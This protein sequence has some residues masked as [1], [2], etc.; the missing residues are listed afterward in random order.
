MQARQYFTIGENNRK[1]SMHLHWLPLEKLLFPNTDR[2]LQEP[3]GL[4]A[5]GGDLSPERLLAAYERGIFPWFNE[6]DPIL[7]WS[8]SPRMVFYPGEVHISRSL[9]KRLKKQDYQ[10]S[11]NKDFLGVIEACSEPRP[12]QDGSIEPGTWISED[13]KQAYLQLHQ[14]GYAHSVE[15]WQNQ[16][17]AGGLYGVSLNKVF[18]G[19]SMFS[20]MNNGSKIALVHLAEWL[21]SW[22]YKLIDCQVY[23]DHLQSLGAVEIERRLFEQIIGEHGELSPPNVEQ[24]QSQFLPLW[25][26]L[27]E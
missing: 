1:R 21:K 15:V 10:V 7:W 16:Q 8:P 19:E 18:F 13:M 9:S 3:N 17:L 14:R 27:S 22:Q 20:R 6:G 23:S 25:H 2:A 5:A 4:L 24:W 11:V 12:T 26:H